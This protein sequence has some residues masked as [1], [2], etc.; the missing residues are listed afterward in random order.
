MTNPSIFKHSSKPTETFGSAKDLAK[1]NV[2]A[3]ILAGGQSTRMGGRNKAMLRINGLTLIEQMVLGPLTY[4][5]TVLLST[6]RTDYSALP[7]NIIAAGYRL[8]DSGCLG[9]LAGIARALEWLN[10]QESYDWLISVPCDTPLLQP[11][12][13]IPMITSASLNPPFPQKPSALYALCHGVDHYAHSLWHKSSLK[14]VEQVLKHHDHSLRWVLK[15][16]N[17][18]PVDLSEVSA[19]ADFLNINSLVDLKAAEEIFKHRLKES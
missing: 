12:W 6:G 16:L 15:N 1:K 9:P 17:A 14:V 5:E 18:R 11:D 2:A 3:V 13:I 19:A 8:D 4:V 7:E 10:S